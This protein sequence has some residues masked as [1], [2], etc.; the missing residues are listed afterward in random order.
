MYKHKQTGFFQQA[1]CC[2]LACP[3]NLQEDD[4]R[5]FSPLLMCEQLIQS[6]AFR[7]RRFFAMG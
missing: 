1:V 2:L 7:N 4:E 6:S 3:S 5:T